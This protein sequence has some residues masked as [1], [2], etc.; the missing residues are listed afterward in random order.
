MFQAR[1]II[2]DRLAKANR[3]KNTLDYLLNGNESFEPFDMEELRF[4]ILAN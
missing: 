2:I 3:K 1:Q 4:D